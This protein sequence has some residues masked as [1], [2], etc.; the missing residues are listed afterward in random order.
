M[1]IRFR[2]RLCY[3]A[4]F[5]AALGALAA[6]ALRA[7]DIG[8]PVSG[9]LFDAD[10][11]TVRPVLG[12][13]GAAT[14]GQP[15]DFG[16]DLKLAAVA[17]SQDYLVAAGSAGRV[18][19]VRL[20]GTAAAQDFD[21]LHGA[22]GRIVFS[23]RGSAALLVNDGTA[24]VYAGLPGAPALARTLRLPATPSALAVSDDAGLVFGVFDGVLSLAGASAEWTPLPGVGEVSLAAFAPSSRNAA[25]V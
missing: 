5:C 8:G 4:V 14:V 9:Y 1:T 10:A 3:P 19:L 13:P 20:G 18:R 24:D 15:L 22:P 23:P 16:F 7:G 25:L 11:R 6:G 12:I 21:A 17:P 2:T